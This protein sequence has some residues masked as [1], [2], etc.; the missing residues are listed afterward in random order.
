MRRTL[1]LLAATVL[2]AGAVTVGSGVLSPASAGAGDCDYALG[3]NSFSARCATSGPAYEFRAWVQCVNGRR[4]GGW[5]AANSG[6]W[7]V[8]SCGPWWIDRLSYGM[9]VRPL[10]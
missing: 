4:D 6:Q 9:D 5:V 2:A 7:S 10:S 8:A 3:Q 1:R